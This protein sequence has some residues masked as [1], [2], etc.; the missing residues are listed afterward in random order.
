MLAGVWIF[1]NWFGE[2]KAIFTQ[3]LRADLILETRQLRRRLFLS[4]RRYW[5]NRRV[6]YHILTSWRRL[7][8]NG[9][10]LI[11]GREILFK[12]VSNRGSGCIFRGVTSKL[13]EPR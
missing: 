13:S 6:L 3:M 10:R 9:Y 5:G 1:E 4:R 11:E 2:G 7:S 12:E 8:L